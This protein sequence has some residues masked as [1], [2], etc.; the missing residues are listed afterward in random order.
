MTGASTLTSD[1]EK[2]KKIHTQLE[3]P[4]PPN[5]PKPEHVPNKPVKNVILSKWLL[6]AKQ[7]E[8]GGGKNQDKWA[9]ASEISLSENNKCI[10]TKQELLAGKIRPSKSVKGH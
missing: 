10:E 3:Y 6:T 4:C 1:V 5:N 7:K 2:P 9:Q 8:G